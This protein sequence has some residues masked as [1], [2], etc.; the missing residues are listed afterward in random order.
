MAALGERW[1]VRPQRRTLL[2]HTSFFYAFGNTRHTSF[3]RENGEE[4]LKVPCRGRV[5]Q[6]LI[7]AVLW[8][9]RTLEA[10]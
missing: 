2:E 5:A 8:G 1:D 9:A 6:L 4:L 10:G 3:F 7:G